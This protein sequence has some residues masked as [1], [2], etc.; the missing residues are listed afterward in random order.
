MTYTPGAALLSVPFVFF[1]IA[2]LG[3][4]TSSFVNVQVAASPS[5]RVS[6]V[7]FS[8]APVH[9][10]A[11][12]VYPVG[13]DSLSVYVPGS[14]YGLQLKLAVRPVRGNP[15]P[16]QVCG[17]VAVRVHADACDVPLLSLITF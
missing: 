9:E 1:T 2:S 6:W 10:S 5:A 17:P 4:A 13:P 12:W 3:F 15:V 16:E 7:P 8:V 11:V 14:R